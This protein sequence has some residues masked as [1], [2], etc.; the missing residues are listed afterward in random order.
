MNKKDQLKQLIDKFVKD[1]KNNYDNLLQDDA[2]IMDQRL[3]GAI[4]LKL[5]RKQKK[6]RINRNKQIE[7]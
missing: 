1:I 6:Y 3:S 2:Q 7:K 5:N 4:D